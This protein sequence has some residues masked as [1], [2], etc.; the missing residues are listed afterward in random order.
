M[1]SEAINIE[2]TGALAWATALKRSG[3]E[4]V[5][6]YPGATALPLFDAL[7]LYAPEIEIV[8][9]RHEQAAVFMASGYAR[10]S[11]KTGVVLV[12]SGPGAT[13]TVTGIADAYMDSIPV[14][15]FT[16]QVAL[17]LIG[18]D[19]FQ[20]SDITGITLP[21]T[22]H[23]YLLKSAS[24]IEHVVDKCFFLASTGRPGPVLV[25][26]PIDVSLETLTTLGETH[27]NM[28]LGY[29]PR[30]I[31][32]PSD[33]KKVAALI[34]EA[35]NPLIVA[36]GGVI[37]SN[38]SKLLYDIA[39]KYQIPVT[40][41]LMGRG[42][43]PEGSE[44]WRGMLGIF[45]HDC[46]RKA[47][48]SADLVLALGTRL[49][50]RV[51]R[52]LKIS[53]PRAKL[54]QV[55]IDAAELD[56]RHKT[57]VSVCADISDFLSLLD[58]KS[59]SG[60][61]A[62]P[63]QEVRDSFNCLQSDDQGKLF[64]AQIV[65][66]VDELVHS[67]E[68]SGQSVFRVTEVGQ[69][70]LWAARHSKIRQPR[71][72][73]SSGGLGAMGFGLPASIGVQLKNPDA[74]VINISGDGSLQ[75]NIQELA[76]LVQESLPVLIVVLNNSALGLVQQYQSEHCD[77]R[78]TASGFP[79]GYPDFS[80]VAEAYGIASYRVQ[81]LDDFEAAL[82]DALRI[83]DGGKPALID[84]IIDPSICVERGEL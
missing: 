24:D 28:P 25:D 79:E 66:R 57:S 6:A 11:G 4:F 54:V 35:Q 71:S 27:A 22:K 31:A 38:A 65:S 63:K 81:S 49:T 18:Y 77:G 80:K 26:I 51:I 15:V 68:D 45:G 44:L 62:K 60:F 59:I 53:A 42:A 34:K 56:K 17:P 67:R 29:E 1:T 78:M 40:S 13:N 39:H 14:V 52:D 3:V 83:V 72:F 41:T 70:Q 10:S 33:V 47:L 75:M 73:I 69:N 20:E 37:S 2:M 7:A 50:E 55:D 61:D 21:I 84:A 58:A 8:L 48:Q 32:D 30:P 43:F 36:G 23:S 16:A 19:A 5:F 74:L 82:M 64:P 46:A 9:P 76:T 12:T